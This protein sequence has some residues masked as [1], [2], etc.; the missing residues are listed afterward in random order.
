M[1]ENPYIP[2]LPLHLMMLT[3]WL[4]SLSAWQCAKN[5]L[6]HWNQPLQ[7]KSP[8][9]DPELFGKAL[10]K[11]VESHAAEV[12]AGVKRYF[13]TPYTRNIKEA[14][15]IWHKGAAKLLD[16][17]VTSSTTRDGTV[18]LFVPSLINRYYILDLEEERSM[19][20]FLAAQGHYPLV[21]DWGVPAEEEKNNNCE[22]YI[23]KILIPAIQYLSK[24][25]GGKIA[26]AG[27]CM[28]GVFALAA[29]QLASKHVSALALL[30]TPWD[31]HC[32]NF[33]PLILDEAYREKISE[34][35]A[36]RATV[37]AEIIQA[38][39]YMTDPWVFEQKFK[40]FA[41]L[42]EDGRAARDFVAL[43]HW[44]NDGVPMTSRTAHD[45]L[46]GWAQENQLA[47]GKWQLGGKT[48]DPK[49]IRMPTFISMPKNDH[50]V[51]YDC[52]LPLARAI[53]QAE[54]INPSAGHVSMIVGHNAK[55]ELWQPLDKWLGKRL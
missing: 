44:V 18:V 43:E 42:D 20:R 15:A 8:K 40:R 36:T 38:L 48:I 28:G 10:Q 2:T 39:F 19:L 46:I 51:P 7:Q 34:I 45:C 5:A 54:V 3:G 41:K 22:D 47:T 16:Y 37:P 11:E 32:D 30:A 25:T 55:R 24:K 17:G 35:L 33:K 14:P 23:L 49:G 1:P 53:R 31:F 13:S 6:P 27:Y 4:N 26:L 29:A 52:A 21:L 50:V 9:L 12:L